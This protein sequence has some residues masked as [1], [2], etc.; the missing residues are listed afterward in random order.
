M[1][2]GKLILRICMAVLFFYGFG[3]C[4]YPTFYGMR[5]DSEA[6]QKVEEFYEYVETLLPTETS[7]REENTEPTLD[8]LTTFPTEPVTTEPVFPELLE[9]MEQYN[10]QIFL[11]KQAGLSDPWA[12]QQ[13]SFDL[14]DFE[15]P[16]GII[17][18]LSIPALN[19]EFPIYLGAT[20]SNMSKGMVHL[21]QTSL[22]IGGMNT[23]SVLAGHRGW[24]GADFLR[25]IEKLQIGDRVTV[26]NLWGELVYEAVEIRI[27]EPHEVEHILIQEGKD[28]LTI[29][30]CHPYASGGKQ[31]YVVYCERVEKGESENER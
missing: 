8:E 2:K 5:T 26:R 21:S 19:A 12:Y 4:L 1:D 9:A 3:I 25:Y 17:G 14:S 30:T 23:N 31:R 28:L 20:S 27:I 6:H 10:R 11:E 13:P 18:V 24:N 29:L 16:D 15:V 7:P 22:P